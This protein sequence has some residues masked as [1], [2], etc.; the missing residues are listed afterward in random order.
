VPCGSAC[1]EFKL[2]SMVMKERAKIF[3]MYNPMPDRVILSIS[4]R[5]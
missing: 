2:Y 3:K 5:D 1:V 4:S